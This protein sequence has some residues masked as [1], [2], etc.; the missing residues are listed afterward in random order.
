MSRAFS[1]FMKYSAN[2]VETCEVPVLIMYHSTITKK[3]E[4]IGDRASVDMAK[5]L[6]EFVSKADAILSTS[7][8]SGLK[9]VFSSSKSH[10]PSNDVV[11]PVDSSCPLPLLPF[12]MFGQYKKFKENGILRQSFAAMWRSLG[13]GTK[14]AKYKDANS[15]PVW[16]DETIFDPWTNF[17]GSQRPDNFT[18]NWAYL[19]YDIMKACY[20]HYFETPAKV[21]EYVTY[22]LISCPVAISCSDVVLNNVKTC[23]AS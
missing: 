19:Q 14:A 20:H 21:D 5:T 23:I 4:I 8:S 6:Q 9:F 13:F 2:F 16:F 22:N 11:Q 17:K 1:S 3:L 7:A 12:Q 18:G 15:K 10:I